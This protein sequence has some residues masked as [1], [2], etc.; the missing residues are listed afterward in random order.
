M[1]WTHRGHDDAM[2]FRQDFRV[3]CDVEMQRVVAMVTVPRDYVN[4]QK[5]S[6]RQI[7]T[8]V[9]IP[10]SYRMFC[11][12]ETQNRPSSHAGHDRQH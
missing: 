1:E 4:F 12:R 3:Q 10:Y 8:G 11:E 2:I 7:D 9:P 5:V 6:M